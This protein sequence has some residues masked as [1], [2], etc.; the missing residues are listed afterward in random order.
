MA[1]PAPFPKPRINPWEAEKTAG[2][3]SSP[4]L[5]VSAE[6]GLATRPAARARVSSC[7]SKITPRA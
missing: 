7:G 4:S 5:Q 3:V 6:A 1:G 2:T